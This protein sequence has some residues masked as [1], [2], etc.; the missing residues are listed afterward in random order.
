VTGCSHNSTPLSLANYTIRSSFHTE[1]RT[2]HEP[3]MTAMTPVRKALTKPLYLLQFVRL[4][5]RDR[6]AFKIFCEQD[7]TA[8]PLSEI[9]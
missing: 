3:R 1:V 6:R 4:D 2:N 7:R 5:K 8:L 9:C